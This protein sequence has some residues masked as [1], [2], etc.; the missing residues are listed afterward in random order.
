MNTFWTYFWPI[1]G[2]AVVIGTIAGSIGYRRPNRRNAALLIGAAL[3]L[4]LALLWHGPFGAADRLASAV[5]SEARLAIYVNEIPE[6][7]GHIHHGPLTREVLLS[8]PAD[9]YQRAELVK[10]ISSLPGVSSAT[11]GGGRDVPLILEAV[12][13]A[14]AGFAI[15]LLFAYVA[16]LRRRHNAQWNW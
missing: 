16:E 11:W 12:L 9:D 4:A 3:C 13:A 8:G 2:S 10:I 7:H 15:G 14:L 6:V 5:D 1:M